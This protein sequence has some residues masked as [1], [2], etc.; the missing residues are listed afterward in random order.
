MAYGKSFT[1]KSSWILGLYLLK[2]NLVYTIAYCTNIYKHHAENLVFIVSTDVQASSNRKK[3]L[4]NN[5]TARSFLEGESPGFW[6]QEYTVMY[7]YR[8][9]FAPEKC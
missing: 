9:K 8:T 6:E 1:D 2:T 7:L 3:D 4:H 5:D